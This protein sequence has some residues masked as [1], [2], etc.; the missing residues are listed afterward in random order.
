MRDHA[1]D[2]RMLMIVSTLISSSQDLGTRHK[3]EFDTIVRSG[4]DF[5]KGRKAAVFHDLVLLDRGSI[6]K[7]IGPRSGYPGQGPNPIHDARKRR[8][9]VHSQF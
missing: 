2:G 3:Q 9:R 4:Y 5:L 8:H 6:L 1:V 7:D